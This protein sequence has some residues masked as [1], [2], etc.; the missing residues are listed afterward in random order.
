MK[1]TQEQ[2]KKRFNSSGV[3]FNEVKAELGVKAK[4]WLILIGEMETHGRT[5][6]LLAAAARILHSRGE[7]GFQSDLTDYLL[8][9]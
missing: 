8:G 1:L 5:D 9:L 2:Q 3:K 7:G 6:E 4:S